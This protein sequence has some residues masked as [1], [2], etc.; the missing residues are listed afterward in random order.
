VNSKDG[1][2]EAKLIGKLSKFF[3]NNVGASQNQSMSHII[4]LRTEVNA[5]ARME[6]F[7]ME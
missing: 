7:S 4:A 1:T 5:L 6:T 3:Q 2:K